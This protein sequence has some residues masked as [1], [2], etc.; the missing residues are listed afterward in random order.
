VYWRYAGGL[1]SFWHQQ[2]IIFSPG[3]T[4][5][6][7]LWII[8]LNKLTLISIGYRRTIFKA[9]TSRQWRTLLVAIYL[10]VSSLLFEFA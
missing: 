6:V 8:N 10:N 4:L 2:K 9:V 1:Q 7:Q 5:Q 3:R